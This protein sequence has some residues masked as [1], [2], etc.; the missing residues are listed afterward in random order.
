MDRRHGMLN[1]N[2]E[3]RK[4]EGEDNEMPTADVRNERK[5]ARIQ[6]TRVHLSI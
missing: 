2:Q 4:E 3:R 1:G 6:S 5:E